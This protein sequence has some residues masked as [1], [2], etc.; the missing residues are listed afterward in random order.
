MYIEVFKEVLVLVLVV[1]MES[2]F[3][4]DNG[5]DLGYSIGFF[6]VQ[7]MENLWVH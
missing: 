4:I 3:C 2:N 6:I 1:M 7:L 5:Y